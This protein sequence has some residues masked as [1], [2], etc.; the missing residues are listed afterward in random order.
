M[1]S[2]EHRRRSTRDDPRYTQPASPVSPASPDYPP[3]SP[4]RPFFIAGQD[5]GSYSSTDTSPD[6]GSD[7][8]RDAPAPQPRARNTRRRSS[9]GQQHY[10]PL[11]PHTP[12]TAD[13]FIASSERDFGWSPAQLYANDDGLPRQRVDSANRAPPSAFPFQVSPLS[14]SSVTLS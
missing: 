14:V 9:V 13:P 1:P 6:T 12:T 5:R 10:A 11:D 4:P 8:D 3:L 7:S 2:R